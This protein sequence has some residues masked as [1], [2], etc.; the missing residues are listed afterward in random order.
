MR[1]QILTRISQHMEL[2]RIVAAYR[3][4]ISLNGTEGQPQPGEDTA[5]GVKHVLVFA[6]QALLIGMEGVGILHNEFAPAHQ[7]EAGPDLIAKLGLNLIEVHRQL[8]IGAQLAANKVTDHFFVRWPQAG[9]MVMTVA[10]AEQFRAVFLHA[11]RSLPQFARLHHRH[12]K[13]MAACVIHLFAHDGFNTAQHAQPNRQEVVD[14]G[15]DTADIPGPEQQSMGNHF[16]IGRIVTQG[17]NEKS[18]I[19]HGRQA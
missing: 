7:A 19:S 14:A 4:G 13:L 16:G 9:L 15:G 11:P 18:G 12:Q 8:F 17:R 6:L 10:E 5:I 1:D 2:M 3:A